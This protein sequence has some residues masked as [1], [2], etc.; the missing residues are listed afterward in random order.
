VPSVTTILEKT[1]SQ[2]KREVLEKWR[3]AVG[4]KQ[5]QQI[6]T[7]AA[8]RG[9]RMH[10]Y[11]EHYVKTGQMRDLPENPFAHPSWFMAAEVILQGLDHV[12]EFWGMEIPLY[13]SGL[14]AGTTDCAGVW[15]NSPAIID[16]KQTNKPKKREWIDE[17]FM[18]LAAY[19]QAHNNMYGTNINTGVVMMC[20]RP[21]DIHATPQYQEFVITGSEF[22]HW[23][24][25]WNRRVELYYL[26][27]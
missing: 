27:N 4:E 2:E 9:T 1:K 23:C 16:F 17:Y 8:N 12:D 25:Q 7:E 20:V 24:D 22:D 13:Y 26:T 14:Y 5:A 6:T 15:K 19:A 3:K 18:Q 11:L 10:T 21:D